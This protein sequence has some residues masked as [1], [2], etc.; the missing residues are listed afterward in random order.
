MQPLIYRLICLNGMIKSDYGMKKYHVG[1]IAGEGADAYRFFKDDTLAA[2]D[3]AFM[4][5]LRDVITA[6]A[7]EAT[8]QAMIEDM[9]E[10][11]ERRVQDPVGA[12]QE[13]TKSYSLT[14]DNSAGIMRHFIE[15]GDLSQ[16]GI[17][18]AITRHSQDVADYDQATDLERLGGQIIELKPGEWRT[19]ETAKAA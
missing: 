8:F 12:I 19:I 4:K 16:Y 17:A 6:A 13:V 9:R 10:T 1:R 5:K 11:T 15:G 2:D 18:Q 7:S 14:E 3:A